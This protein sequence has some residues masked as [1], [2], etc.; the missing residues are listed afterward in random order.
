MAINEGRQNRRTAKAGSEKELQSRQAPK[1]DARSRI[2]VTFPTFVVLVLRRRAKDQHLC[3][4]AVVA[5]LILDNILMD[6]VQTMSSQSPE[7]TQAV[8]EWMHDAFTRKK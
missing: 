7:F 1:N 2:T 3:V 5:T 6:E 8:R 4:S